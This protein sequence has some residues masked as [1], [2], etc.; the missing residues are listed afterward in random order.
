MVSRTSTCKRCN[1]KTVTWQK[2]DKGKWFLTEVFE[3]PRGTDAMDEMSAYTDFHS[4]YCGKNEIHIAK[5]VGILRDWAKNQAEHKRREDENEAQRIE[6]EAE[7][8]AKFLRMTPDERVELRLALEQ[9]IKREQEGLTMDYMSEYN[10]SLV[11]I[12]GCR[13]ELAMYADFMEDVEDEA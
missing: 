8:L 7:K 6:V 2:S 1:S 12:E 4:A 11:I 5:Q 10:R 3:Y 13:A 9:I